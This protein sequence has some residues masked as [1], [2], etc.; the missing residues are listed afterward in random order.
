MSQQY[1]KKSKK[2]LLSCKLESEINFIKDN[3][4]FFPN[5]QQEE[6]NT[7]ATAFVSTKRTAKTIGKLVKKIRK[8]DFPLKNYDTNFCHQVIVLTSLSIINS[9]LNVVND[10]TLCLFFGV[11]EEIMHHQP[12]FNT[13][14]KQYTLT[15][16]NDTSS[17]IIIHSSTTNTSSST[18]GNSH[19]NFSNNPSYY[20]TSSSNNNNDSSKPWYL[21]NVKEYRSD[22]KVLNTPQQEIIENNQEEDNDS[23][24]EQ[25]EEKEIETYLS[26]E[27]KLPTTPTTTT[28]PN[29]IDKSLTS[30]STLPQENHGKENEIRKA[31]AP[32]PSETDMIEPTSF[33]QPFLP[34]RLNVVKSTT[35]IVSPSSSKQPYYYPP[36][37][38]NDSS[39]NKQQIELSP[40][41]FIPSPYFNLPPSTQ[42][43]YYYPPPPIPLSTIPIVPPPT[44]STASVTAVPITENNDS[45]EEEEDEESE[46]DRHVSNTA[47]NSDQKQTSNN[48]KKGNRR[49]KVPPLILNP[50]CE[51]PEISAFISAPSRAHIINGIIH[52]RRLGDKFRTESGYICDFPEMI[53]KEENLQAELIIDKHYTLKIKFELSEDINSEINENSIIGFTLCNLKTN[54]V[55]GWM[56]SKLKQ[57]KKISTLGIY[58]I[59]LILDECRKTELLLVDSLKHNMAS[60]PYNRIKYVSK[61]KQ[62]KSYYMLPYL[63]KENERE[64]ELILTFSLERNF[65]EKRKD[66][67]LYQFN[68]FLTD[69]QEVHNFHN[70][71]NPNSNFLEI[72]T[73]T[74]DK[75]LSDSDKLFTV[76][77]L[78]EYIAKY[79]NNIVI[80]ANTG[81]F[82]IRSRA[83]RN[84]TNRINKNR[85][86]PQKRDENQVPGVNNISFIEDNTGI[87]LKK[88]KI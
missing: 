24:E 39:N 35:T 69:L 88:Q 65:G 15:T 72:T 10:L 58:P 36:I 51:N 46:V 76:E 45:S 31:I 21:Q 13:Q 57:S 7:S 56:F 59:D 18:N 80:L 1:G 79:L 68:L 54:Q 43:F 49:R 40:A 53:K 75:R 86:Y 20:G 67:G 81:H 84:E 38:M 73:F 82:T 19:N 26:N 28:Q 34:I 16:S 5:F 77:K 9:T 71:N 70:N 52:Q 32:P 83:K 11:I 25:E 17:N 23:E 2:L 6:E 8:N 22:W 33:R 14:P 78:N 64:Y 41:P 48:S 37:A 74:T 4:P 12:S 60:Y 87:A 47:S 62:R 55:E 30:S 44:T 42:G 85:G 3:T 61:K 27:P 66:F 29:T 63:M 50:N